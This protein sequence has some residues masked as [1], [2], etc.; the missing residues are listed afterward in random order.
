MADIA[1]RT[2]FISYSHEDR[3]WLKRLQVHM[4]PL[5]RDEQVELWDDTMIKAGA[6]WRSEIK[7]AL[8]SARVAILLVSADFLASDF[9][10]GDELPTLLTAAKDEGAIII[11]VIISY[12]Q[13]RQTS[14]AD[15]Q[16]IN[17]PDRP[18]IKLSR[19][20]RENVFAETA[21]SI[22]SALAA[23]AQASTEAVTDTASLPD[24]VLDLAARVE[25]ELTSAGRSFDTIVELAAR[26][27]RRAA[28]PLDYREWSAEEQCA[29][30]RRNAASMAIVVAD[31]GPELNEA[32]ARLLDAEPAIG[33][34]AADLRAQDLD[35]EGVGMVVNLLAAVD[36]QLRV[37]AAALDE[38]LEELRRRPTKEWV[39]VS[40]E[41]EALKTGLNVAEV[42]VSAWWSE[43]GVPARLP[44]R[45]EVGDVL[46]PLDRRASST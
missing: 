26:L 11:P 10:A 9:I 46:E 3:R 42:Q 23:V 20:D 18:V 13:F 1:R 38:R 36:R 6:D 44:R 19:A 41:L 15:F 30:G 37:C 22:R 31:L 33:E 14:L 34:L 25:R 21:S 35:P 12:S 40:Q 24:Q 43:L 29:I 5:V 2:V 45:P 28:L 4:R 32:Q 17:S 8:A 16:P 7:H 27:R 39:P